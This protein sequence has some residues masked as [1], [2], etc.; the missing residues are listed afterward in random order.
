MINSIEKLVSELLLL[1]ILLLNNLFQVTYLFEDGGQDFTHHL[2]LVLVIAMR[3]LTRLPQSLLL[4]QLLSQRLWF[5]LSPQSL[6][7]LK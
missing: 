2:V 4:V 5:L 3:N 6:V 7:L 1:D